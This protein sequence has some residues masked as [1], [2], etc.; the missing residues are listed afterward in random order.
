LNGSRLRELSDVL[1]ELIHHG[2][3]AATMR[4]LHRMSAS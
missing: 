3:E 1:H 4:D 2:A